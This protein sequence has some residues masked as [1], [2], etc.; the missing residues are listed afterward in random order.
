MKKVGNKEDA[1]KRIDQQR[2]RNPQS[3]EEHN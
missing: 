1:G 3:E 2:D